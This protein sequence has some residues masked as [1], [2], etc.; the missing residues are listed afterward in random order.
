MALSSAPAGYSAAST[1]LSQTLGRVAS[2]LAKSTTISLYTFV[3][4]LGEL[5]DW[6]DSI[7][8]SLKR[9]HLALN[10]LRMIDFLNLRWFDAVMVATKP[11]LASLTRF[12][13]SSLSPTLLNFFRFCANVA[14][15]A[16]RETLLLM[17]HLEAQ[18]LM[19]GLTGFEKHFLVQ[20][21]GVLA[22]STFVQMGREEERLRFKECIEMLSRLPGGR[23]HS[24][25]SEMN[26]LESRL[27]R[28]V[29]ARMDS[30]LG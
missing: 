19:K 21:A 6:V 29:A 5:Q 12:G 28:F 10:S 22:L 1:S 26:H 30:R 17:K 11:F 23:H 3:H 9:I 20:S 25:I 13:G 7:P 16:A 15:L 14:S 2:C 18:Q 8:N 4:H 27:K 24:L